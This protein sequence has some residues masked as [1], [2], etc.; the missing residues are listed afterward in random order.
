M[1]NNSFY[2]TP[3]ELAEKMLIGIDWTF[4][5]EI[6]EP[7]AGKGDL[8][9]AIQ[10]VQ[11]RHFDRWNSVDIHIDT[12]EA[13]PDL[14]SI[15]K[16]KGFHVI[17]NDFLNFHTYKRYD[18]I[19]MNPP[20]ANGD[21]HL[22]KAINL[23]ERW[24]GYVVCLLNAETIRNP[25]CN[26]RKALAVKLKQLD[27]EI[28]FHEKAF[29]D[30]ERKTNIDIAMVKVKIPRQAYESTILN[31]LKASKEMENLGSAEYTDIVVDDIVKAA[32]SKYEFEVAAGVRFFQ[33]YEALRPI[34]SA[35]M[36]GSGDMIT[37]KVDRKNDADVN[38]YVKCVR[39]KYWNTL[40]RN[41][42][43]MRLLTNNLRA[44]YCSM[45][46]KLE[47]YDFSLYNIYS[48]QY[49][50][51]KE[52]CQGL[53]DTILALFDEFS[54][55]YSW[56]GETSNNI[57]YYNGWKTNDAF[58]INKKVIIPLSGW[59][60]MCYSWG[61]FK[62]TYSDVESKLNDIIRV[63]DYLSGTD[64]PVG[65]LHRILQ[66]AEN[67]GTS[68]KI[69]CPYVT[70]TFYKKGTCHIEFQDEK[71][72]DKFNIFG[73]QKKGWL[74]PSYG[75]SHYDDMSQEE[76]NVVDEFQGKEAYQNVLSNKSSYLFDSSKLMM[77]DTNHS[78]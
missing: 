62:P 38:S 1:F 65:Y 43:F 13:E 56:I 69:K 51:S 73:S 53:E 36:D 16:E 35:S 64:T 4:T 52:M 37:L 78:F 30:A 12:I 21:L 60:D 9:E 40:F 54:H 22:L 24:G 70:L 8:A 15:L 41:P 5:R 39:K 31:D 6:L 74:P 48:I 3:K 23:M 58:K 28:T 42:S 17:G 10:S 66:E 59:R 14:I 63:F 55:T 46:N 25:Y 20:F 67:T 19:I 77:L 29:T 45:V 76:Q 2:P 50:M 7:S 34:M 11:K 44:K 27:A 49:E 75:Y 18:A 33:E 72:L 47:D 71:L 26:S 68:K 61:G 32:V 57:H